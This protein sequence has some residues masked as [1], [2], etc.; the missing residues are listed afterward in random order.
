MPTT[1]GPSSLPLAWTTLDSFW[2]LTLQVGSVEHDVPTVSGHRAAVLDIQWCP[3]NDDLI[4]SGSEDMTVKLWTIPEGG[5]TEKLVEPV[6]DLVGHQRKVNIVRWHP[7][8]GD[9]I[10][11]AG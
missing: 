3:F 9:V 6:V 8:A 11:S 7:T 1:K 5:I 10:L 2:L 4:A